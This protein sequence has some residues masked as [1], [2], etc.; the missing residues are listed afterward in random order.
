[1]KKKTILTQEQMDFIHNEGKELSVNEVAKTLRIGKD[2][3]SGYRERNGL[4]LSKEQWM[5]IRTNKLSSRSTFSQEEIDF[6]KAN[7][8]TMTSGE[9]EKHLKRS[10]CGIAGVMRKNGLVIPKEILEQRRLQ[11][12]YKKGQSPPNKG[13]KWDDFMSNEAQER[14]RATTYKKGNEPYNTKWD[15]AE[16]LTKDGY[17]EVR[18]S[19]GKWELKH[20]VEWEKVNGKVPAAH[21]LWFKDRNTCNCD[22]S[23]LE[24]IHRRENR[25]RNKIASTYDPELKELLKAHKQLIHTVNKVKNGK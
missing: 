8:L 20:R 3:I 4:T 11:S 15:G 16:R 5:A 1:M 7:Y 23:N 25:L 10:G 6:I 2:A 24:L 18:V 19:K 21:C 14:S 9:M 12:Y 22:L 13:K 17:I